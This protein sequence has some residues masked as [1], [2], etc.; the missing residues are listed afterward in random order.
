MYS[1]WFDFLAVGLAFWVL[2][3]SAHWLVE[4][5]TTLARHWQISDTHIG[6]SVI[7]FGSSAPELFVN[8]AS[9]VKGEHDVV[10]GSIL[11]S[12]N[13]NTYFVLGMIALFNRVWV[14]STTITNAL[15][16]L[17]LAVTVCFVLVNDRI[18]SDRHV[19][20]LDFWDSILLLGLFAG[21]I[22]FIYR[23]N[24]EMY[25]EDIEAGQRDPLWTGVLLTMAACLGLWLSANVVVDSAVLVARKLGL[26]Q[27]LIAM[28]LVALGTTLPEMVTGI[29]AAFQKRTHLA[30][31]SLIGSNLMNLL[32]IL[33]VCGLL[34]SPLEYN[35]SM[36]YDMAFLLLG[37]VIFLLAILTNHHSTLYR[38]QAVIMLLFFGVYMY[39]R[40]IHSN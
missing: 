33:S 18:F 34:A 35:P 40:F 13:F 16:Y 38:W 28:T 11:G 4:G 21:F 12:S 26:S 19:D 7:A 30:V 8:L 29:V 23:S 5:A 1:L 24:A 25:Q 20:L 31:A 14:R 3:R 22:V 9:S 6:L 10:F 39:S 2:V 36:S 27:K 37:T 17:L 15:P 32:L